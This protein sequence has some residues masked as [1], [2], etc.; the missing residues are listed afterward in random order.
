LP[1]N[2]RDIERAYTSMQEMI[3]RDAHRLEETFQTLK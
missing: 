1:K 3:F 2:L